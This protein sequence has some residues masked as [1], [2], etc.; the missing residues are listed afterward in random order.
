MNVLFFLIPKAKVETIK[1]TFT[2]RQAVEKMNECGYAAIPIINDKGE[3]IETITN[4]DILHYL[5]ENLKLD[6][7]AAER[8]PVMA[9]NIKR[10]TKAIKVYQSM[11]NLM[12]VAKTQNFVP[13]VDD[14][15]HF[16]GMVTRGAIISYFETKL[17]EYENKSG[18]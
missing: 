4:G 13:V 9:V 11:E 15:N 1:D 2:L 6:L 12:E 16:I 7:Y 3:Y 8:V 17:K 5:R 18:E 14:S 10:K